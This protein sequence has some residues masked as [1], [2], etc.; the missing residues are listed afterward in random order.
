MDTLLVGI[1]AA[2]AIGLA[3]LALFA[4]NKKSACGSCCVAIFAAPASMGGAFQYL[5]S[6][7]ENAIALLPKSV[8]NVDS[9]WADKILASISVFEK[10]IC[11]G[12]NVLL[13]WD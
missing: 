9:S 6:Q 8:A 1:A 7:H 3:S 4:K 5:V 2:L 12:V 13:C 10:G 11:S